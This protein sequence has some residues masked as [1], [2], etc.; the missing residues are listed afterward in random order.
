MSPI[1][2]LLTFLF[3]VFA[4]LTAIFY[5]L[6]S[7]LDAFYVFSP[8]QLHDLSLRAIAAHGN[9]TASVVQFIKTELG[10]DSKH[11][12]AQYVN[13]EEEWVFNNAGGA[14]GAMYIIHASE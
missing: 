2:F 4:P 13:R 5:N 6:N 11:G 14:M 10:D 12:V 8:P 3:V 7:N 9:D 1:P